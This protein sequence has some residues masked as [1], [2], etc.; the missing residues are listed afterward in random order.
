[1]PEAVAEGMVGVIIKE[2][3][4]E[5]TKVVTLKIVIVTIIHREVI[6]VVAPEEVIVGAP[7]A[8]VPTVVTTLM[9]PTVL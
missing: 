3:I 8:V 4:T 9:E 1:M 6:E 2:I 5:G 7:T